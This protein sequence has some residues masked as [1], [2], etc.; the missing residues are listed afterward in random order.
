MRHS[1]KVVN[2]RVVFDN[3]QVWTIDCAKLE[4]ERVD[5]TIEKPKK[6]RSG[7]QNNYYHGVMLPL[8]CETTGYAHDEMHEILKQLFFSRDVEVAGKT[9]TIAT[10]KTDSKAFSERVDAIR[11]WAQCELGVRIPTPNETDYGV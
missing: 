1:A 3:P 2:G 8:L 10:T 7:Q 11:S 9:V 5:I 4:G 6:Q